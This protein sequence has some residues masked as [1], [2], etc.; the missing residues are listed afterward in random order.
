MIGFITIQENLLC[1]FSAGHFVFSWADTS[2]INW[3]NAGFA[4]SPVAK[5]SAQ[6]IFIS[7]LNIEKTPLILALVALCPKIYDLEINLPE[8]RGR[9]SSNSENMW[10]LF[11]TRRWYSHHRWLV[12]T[13]KSHHISY[14][15]ELSAK[16]MFSCCILQKWFETNIFVDVASFHYGERSRYV[17]PWSK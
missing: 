4:W 9:L 2:P 1:C 16:D 5:F 3:R 15:H 14:K 8:K 11:A 7:S 13:E 17:H 6:I 10:M 12:A